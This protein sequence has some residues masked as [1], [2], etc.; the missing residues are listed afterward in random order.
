M[1]EMT[2]V[3]P[4]HLGI[5]HLYKIVKQSIQVVGHFTLYS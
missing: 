4:L 2:A 3:A 5:I 1:F